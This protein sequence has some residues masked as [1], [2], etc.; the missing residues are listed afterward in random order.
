MHL[1]LKI[2]RTPP[3]CLT[4]MVPSSHLLGSLNSCSGQWRLVWRFAAPPLTKP[5]AQGQG[6]AQETRPHQCRASPSGWVKTSW[7]MDSSQP[8]ASSWW[9]VQAGS[10][11]RTKNWSSKGPFC[12]HGCGRP[13]IH[14]FCRIR[15]V[16]Y[17]S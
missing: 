13:P 7:T 12:G 14:S 17:P 4:E 5:R 8:T 10:Q 6:E 11:R 15:R 2:Q 16:L 1:L 3:R 9:G